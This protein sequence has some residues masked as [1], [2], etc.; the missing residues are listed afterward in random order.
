MNKESL[1]FV[2]VG[3]VDHGKSTL[4]GRLLYDTGSLKEGVI[5]KVKRVSEEIGKEFEYAYLLDALKEE[6][7]QGI[8]IDTTK[9]EFSTDKRQ[10]TII[11]AP[12]H[13]EFLKNMISG[14]S[15][16][17]AA[18]LIVDADEGVREQTKRHAYILYLLGIKQ[19]HVI[20]NKMDLV[21]FS[22][23]RYEEVR[24][25]IKDYL[26]RLEI[27]PKKYIPISAKLG[28]NVI[29]KS[30]NME[31]GNN[32]TVL[33]AI[34]DFEKLEGL[35]DKPLRFPIQDI[36]KFDDRRIISGR[37]E[38][39]FLEVGQEIR[40]LP[41]N[42]KTKVISIEQWKEK[43]KKTS[44]MCGEY[45][46][47][48]VSDNHFFKRGDVITSLN[49]LPTI[50][51]LFGCSLFWMGKNDL[52]KGKQYILKLNSQEIPCEVYEVQGVIDSNTL[53][54]IPG[55]DFL[56]KHDVGNIIIKTKKPIVYDPFNE[57]PTN[58]RFVLV[59]ELQVSG[60]GIIEK[61]SKEIKE[62][63]V[64]ETSKEVSV[65]PKS[66]LIEP[67][68]RHK[69]QGHKGNVVWLTGIPGCGKEMIAKNLE[70]ELFKKGKSVC[71]L[72]ASNIRLT[73][74]S[75]L[76]FSKESRYEHI[77]R[78]AEVANILY[79]LGHI[80]IV[81]A[82]SPYSDGRKYAR[83]IIG[84][85]NFIEVFVDMPLDICKEI[86]PRGIYTKAEKG[87]RK[88]VPGVDIEYE[89]S[90]YLIHTL[91]INKKEFN[92]SEKVTEL[93]SLLDKNTKL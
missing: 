39:G 64:I 48:T 6:Q 87:E 35:E 70:K 42:Q 19:V 11:D 17:E 46:G 61:S 41:S 92:I 75:D 28:D 83:S 47:I 44:L 56:S 80:V 2:I 37:I 73:L 82:V 36:Y 15:N 24:D 14:A 59:D 68:D 89:K 78:L 63:R 45:A 65:V 67:K 23:E 62:R 43:E 50:N 93:L 85:D 1:K 86:N 31:W 53:E 7:E 88:G 12:G 81:S 55:K 13:K 52:I 57:I 51:N 84:V 32:E 25:E 27:F 21:D 18:I 34:D 8:T 54:Q 10:Y 49:D 71:Y 91:N 5:E 4:I 79:N 26:V 74:N 90:D 76:N 16:A 33:S 30:P 9:I 22:Q 29:K 40:L 58:G 20:I 72:D 69:K 60:G 66:S 77:R 38:S 3:H